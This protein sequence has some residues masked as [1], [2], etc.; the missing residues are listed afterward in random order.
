MNGPCARGYLGFVL[1]VAVAGGCGDSSPGSFL[2]G[3]AAGDGGRALDGGGIHDAG[4]LVD[5]GLA[6]GGPA[7]DAGIRLLS[8]AVDD[9]PSCACGNWRG[10]LVNGGEIFQ[11]CNCFSIPSEAFRC[12]RDSDCVVFQDSCAGDTSVPDIAVRL[13][14]EACLIT[15]RELYCGRYDHWQRDYGLCWVDCSRPSSLCPRTSCVAGRCHATIE[16][17]CDGRDRYHWPEYPYTSPTVSG[18]TCGR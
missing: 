2:D 11:V 9:D 17:S 14:W 4:V 18:A 13:D 15:Y 8:T 12:T 3:G 5:A 10:V 6:D 7:Q 1:L 16:P